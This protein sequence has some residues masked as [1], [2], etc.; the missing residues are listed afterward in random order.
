VTVSEPV[1]GQA[2]SQYAN[3]IDDKAWE[4]LGLTGQ[5][6][7]LKYYSRSFVDHE[8]PKVRALVFLLEHRHWPDGSTPAD[9][10]P[11]ARRPTRRRR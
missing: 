8:D 5:E 4:L 6:F 3:L 11:A 1:A 10:S 7:L 2:T 9:A